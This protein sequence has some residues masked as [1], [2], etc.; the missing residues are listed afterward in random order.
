MKLSN[1]LKCAYVNIAST[2]RFLVQIF[3][4]FFISNNSL[5]G[6]KGSDDSLDSEDV[7]DTNKDE[8]DVVVASSVGCN[9]IDGSEDVPGS[10]DTDWFSEDCASEER[11]SGFGKSD[12]VATTDSDWL[13]RDGIFGK[14]S[15]VVES[16]ISCDN[17]G[18]VVITAMDS[19][20]VHDV[21]YLSLK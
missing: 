19:L 21:Q 11:P 6:G 14:S 3:F 7:C 12:N 13:F 5:T 18:L 15:E 1:R 17:N 20:M 16:D 10:N 8:D 2:D 4:R 9:E